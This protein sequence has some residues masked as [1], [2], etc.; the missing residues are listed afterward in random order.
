EAFAGILAAL[1]VRE[2]T[3]RGQNLEATLVNGLAALDYFGTMHWQYA[4]SAGETPSVTISPSSG[5]MAF[6]RTMLYLATQDS[7]FLTT[8]GMLP[9]EVRAL[10]RIAGLEHLLDDPRFASAPKFPAVE[11]AQAWEMAMWTAFRAKPYAEWLPALLADPDVAFETL[12]SSEEALDHPQMV[13]NGEVVTVDDPD[14]GPVRVVGPVAWLEKTPATVD[15]LAP[16]QGAHGD[17]LTG[18]APLRASGPPPT[19]ALAGVTIIECGYFF[20]MPFAMTLAASLGARVIKIEGQ[21]GD[22]FRN[23]FGAPETTAVRVMEGK[24]SLS[25][26]LAG[27]RGR[28][29]MHRLVSEANAF[30]TSFRTGVP[31][32]L[33]LDYDT[34]RA[35]NPSLVYL[36][37]TG[38]GA[39]G[40]FA[41]R[42]MYATA[43]QAA[44]G[45]LRRHAG[46]WLDPETTIDWPVEA[47]EAVVKP[48][49]GAPTDGDSNAAL[50]VLSSLLIGL[51]HQRRTGEGQ[52]VRTSMLGGNA[53]MYS[54]DFCSYRDKP[55]RRGPDE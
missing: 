5:V 44:A 16:A 46:V 22:P 37:A 26:D 18:P 3:G 7:R 32:R 14:H 34:L 2:Q 17:P 10:A 42:A 29:V 6:T 9:K 50:A 35:I 23:S 28:E 30:V 4:R 52:L 33:G 8:T 25:I 55:P 20:A 13:H 36:H 27:A 24:E 12:V 47:I 49:L 54:D 19:H 38:Y 1:M 53:L 40:P 43:A 31:E 11:D 39:D 15:R 48:R 41:N 51:T 21:F 45:G